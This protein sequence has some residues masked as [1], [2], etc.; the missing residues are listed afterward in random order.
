MS[1]VSV[2]PGGHDVLTGH[3]GHS[4]G[5]R[6]QG[7]Q[8]GRNGRDP[9]L[10]TNAT[11]PTPEE[12]AA[13][14]RHVKQLD[15]HRQVCSFPTYSVSR[16]PSPLPQYGNEIPSSP[17][18]V[19]Y[20]VVSKKPSPSTHF[21]FPPV[22][23]TVDKLLR[24]KSAYVVFQDLVTDRYVPANTK[25]KQPGDPSTGHLVIVDLPSWQDVFL[26]FSLYR[27][28]YYPD[29]AIPFLAYSGII[30]GLASRKPDVRFWLEYDQR[31]RQKMAL[32]DSDVTG[33]YHEDR[34]IVKAVK[35]NFKP[36]ATTISTVARVVSTNPVA[37]LN[38]VIR[39][40]P[41]TVRNASNSGIP[42]SPIATLSVPSTSLAPVPV[43]THH[44]TSVEIPDEAYTPLIP[45]RFAHALKEYPDSEFAD[46]FVN[47]LINGFRPGYTGPDVT[48]ITPNARTAREHPEVVRD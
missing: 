18:P 25:R 39:T 2:G 6:L 36:T 13:I 12:I 44:F 21:N 5:E 35:N 17:T 16:A 7:E 29:M 3:M 42:S 20:S 48:Q 9:W 8:A 37:A 27:S 43:T 23:P 33:W 30:R 31:F 38:H 10:L 11:Y 45:E 46:Y 47:G 15:V 26:T 32:P 24:Q 28:Y 40:M 14:L 1:A 19:V 34:D 41:I 22:T 4:S